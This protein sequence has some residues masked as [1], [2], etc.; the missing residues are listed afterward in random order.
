MSTCHISFSTTDVLVLP[1]L[2]CPRTPF[3]AHWAIVARSPEFESRN[4]PLPE[5]QS[6]LSE[7]D[8]IYSSREIQRLDGD[9]VSYYDS[10][11]N[12]SRRET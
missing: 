1:V 9:S 6:S 12:E 8:L 5:L 7:I 4:P 3:L 10:A 2:V 11:A